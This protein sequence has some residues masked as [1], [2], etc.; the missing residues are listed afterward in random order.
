M[1]NITNTTQINV[2]GLGEEELAK[3][4]KQVEERRLFLKKEAEE[5][6]LEESRKKKAELSA[7]RKERAKEVEDAYKEAE[8][9]RKKAD[10]LMKQFITDYGYFHATFDR[11][12][13]FPSI[14]DMFF[15]W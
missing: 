5:R 13:S 11:P 10:D 8:K 7:A 9:A 15:N 6:A 2:E 14:W 4:A 3:L 12:V 1:T